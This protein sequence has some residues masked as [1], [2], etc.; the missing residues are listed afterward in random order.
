MRAQEHHIPIK[1]T[2]RYFTYGNPKKAKNLLL[3]F[4]GYGQLSSYFIR[5]FYCLNPD[6]YFVVCPEGLNRFYLKSTEGRIGASWMTKEDREND[7]VDYIN[8]LN[9]LCLKVGA[10]NSFDQKIVLGFSQGGATASRFVALGQHSF[11]QVILWSTVFPPDMQI[12]YSHRF[13]NSTNH[14]VIG[15]N[16]QYHTTDSLE[17]HIAEIENKGLKFRLTKF[18]GNH[19]ID[20]E[21][22]LTLLG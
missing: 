18:V 17:N 5:N 11:N 4:H 14:F 10:T 20:K 12:D 21:T 2:G 16:D 6:D 3:A 19:N 7:I 22:L 15:D 13:N 8:F 1:T 9:E